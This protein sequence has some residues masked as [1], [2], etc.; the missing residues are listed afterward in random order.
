VL[1]GTTRI[2]EETTNM[3][4]SLSFMPN[5]GNKYFMSAADGGVKIYDF[6]KEVVHIQA[7]A[8][9]CSHRRPLVMIVIT[10]LSPATDV[11]FRVRVLALATIRGNIHGLLRLHQGKGIPSFT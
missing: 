2:D 8:A 11:N 9:F 1:E 6:E 7:A 5:C 3:A 10:V 4:L